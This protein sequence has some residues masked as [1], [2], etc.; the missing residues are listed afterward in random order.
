M[1]LRFFVL[2]SWVACNWRLL[3][4]WVAGT[5]FYWM[6]RGNWLVK[7]SRCSVN[8][9]DPSFTDSWIRLCTDWQWFIWWLV[10]WMSL[11]LLIETKI[12]ATRMKAEETAIHRQGSW[13]PHYI[14][15]LPCEAH[16]TRTRTLIKWSTGNHHK[17]NCVQHFTA[18]LFK[19]K[20]A[21]NSIWRMN[22][23]TLPP[24]YI[25]VMANW[26][27]CNNVSGKYFSET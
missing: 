17:P 18:H 19:Y 26:H 9:K 6:T 10:D 13:L 27:Y 15:C 8:I 4:P 1:W 7:Q 25:L 2:D 22:F 5:S 14:K 20:E 16:T 3:E 23:I 21:W 24:D 11:M 12:A